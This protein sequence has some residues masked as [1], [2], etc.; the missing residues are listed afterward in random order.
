MGGTC[1]SEG[2]Q[3]EKVENAWSGEG[4]N[5]GRTC[6]SV[7]DKKEPKYTPQS[8]EEEP[9]YSPQSYEEEPEYSPLYDE[10]YNPSPYNDM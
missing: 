8:N 1:E 2:E 5:W 6:E 9:E 10:E 4:W 7:V 3:K